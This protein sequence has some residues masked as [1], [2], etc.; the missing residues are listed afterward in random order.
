MFSSFMLVL[1]PGSNEGILPAKMTGTVALCRK[2]GC[3]C[4]G[5]LLC[6]IQ[7]EGPRLL[8]NRGHRKVREK[9]PC[10][11]VV[12]MLFFPLPRELAL[13]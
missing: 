10:E 8:E 13:T 5:Q 7:E 9:C 12:P 2:T 11:Q 6:D 1:L 3:H 4:P